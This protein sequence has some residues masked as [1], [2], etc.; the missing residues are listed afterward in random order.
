[1]ESLVLRPRLDEVIRYSRKVDFRQD[2][3]SVSEKPCPAGMTAELR[4]I[5]RLSDSDYLMRKCSGAPTFATQAVLASRSSAFAALAIPCET[6]FSTATSVR[7]FFTAFLTAFLPSSQPSFLPY[8]LPFRSTSVDGLS[9][10]G[11]L[12]KLTTST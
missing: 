1:M 11:E 6:A 3:G 4:G 9:R 5:L 10:N 2:T 8:H 7:P 12:Y